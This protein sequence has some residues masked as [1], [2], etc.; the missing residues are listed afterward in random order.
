MLTGS[1]QLERSKLFT[2]TGINSDTYSTQMEYV[3]FALTLQWRDSISLL[4]EEAE[5]EEKQQG[6]HLLVIVE[7][8]EHMDFVTFLG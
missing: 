7:E 6:N 3:Q 8:N 2:Y 1:P 4:H 5:Q